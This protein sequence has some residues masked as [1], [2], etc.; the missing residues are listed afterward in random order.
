LLNQD[1]A[2]VVA[3]GCGFI[4]VLKAATSIVPIVFISG[5]D[6]ISSGF[7]ESFNRPGGN[8]TGIDLRNSEL[9]RKR[10]SPLA[11]QQGIGSGIQQYQTLVK[12][13]W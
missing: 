1:P 13:Y 6:P 4:S 11:N 10:L 3:G 7:V 9:I 5:L 2:A 8:V 12:R